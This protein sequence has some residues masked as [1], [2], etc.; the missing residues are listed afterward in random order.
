MKNQFTKLTKFKKNE[1]KCISKGVINNELTS[2]MEHKKT[3]AIIPVSQQA[4]KKLSNGEA[5]D[6]SKCE[7]ADNRRYYYVKDLSKRWKKNNDE[8]LDILVE[9][10]CTLF[11]VGSTSTGILKIG[12]EDICIYEEYVLALEKSLN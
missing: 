3:G 7:R 11:A 9:H 2:Y 1:Q 10:E 8:V 4:F 6:F 12:I 5:L